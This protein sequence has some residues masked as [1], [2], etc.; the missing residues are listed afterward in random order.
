MSET[1]NENIKELMSYPWGVLF[2]DLIMA[3]EFGEVITACVRLV[4]QLYTKL[5]MFGWKSG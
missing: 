4:K 2:D 5:N 1:S 3:D